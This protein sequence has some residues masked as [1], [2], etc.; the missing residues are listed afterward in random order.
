MAAEGGGAAER[1]DGSRPGGVGGSVNERRGLTYTLLE[2][3][4]GGLMHPWGRGRGGRAPAA[5]IEVGKTEAED[6]VRYVR[7]FSELR[8]LLLWSSSSERVQ[9]SPDTK[10]FNYNSGCE[11]DCGCEC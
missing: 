4:R 11:Y 8:Y 6:M 9:S 3:R 2:N 1:G 7:L 10:T 5:S